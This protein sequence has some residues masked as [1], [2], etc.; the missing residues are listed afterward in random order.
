MGFEFPDLNHGVPI[1][2]GYGISGSHT[3][4]EARTRDH[5][6]TVLVGFLQSCRH[7]VLPFWWLMAPCLPKHVGSQMCWEQRST[8]HQL[9]S[10][11]NP[12]CLLWCVSYVLL[13]ILVGSK[14]MQALALPGEIS[15]HLF[16][17][18]VKQQHWELPKDRERCYGLILNLI[19]L[20]Y[21]YNWPQGYRAS[22]LPPLIHHS[23]R[24]D[25]HTEMYSEIHPLLNACFNL[26]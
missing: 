11:Q 25:H 4:P 18:F 16:F 20:I 23:H 2:L 15:P 8:K 13:K 1:F 12:L 14:A 26:G 3:Q 7:F 9:F 24:N 10:Y 22:E 19:Y 21:T 17:S 5:S 6:N